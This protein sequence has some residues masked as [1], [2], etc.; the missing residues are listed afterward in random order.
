MLTGEQ[1]TGELLRPSN[2]LFIT[3][4]LCFYWLDV[5]KMCTHSTTGIKNKQN[6][7]L[8]WF[9]LG[10]PLRGNQ[11]RMVQRIELLL[12][13]LLLS[14]MLPLLLVLLWSLPLLLLL[15]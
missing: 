7:F 13:L 8:H 9:A 3:R 14:L 15:M 5:Q 4:N 12:K 10:G 11:E 2:Y 1:M 6:V